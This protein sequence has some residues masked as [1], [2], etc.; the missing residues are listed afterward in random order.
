MKIKVSVTDTLEKVITHKL[1]G[2]F[3]AQ[4]EKK[5]FQKPNKNQNKFRK[6]I[7]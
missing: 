2:F 7:K 3:L 1:H 4:P 5:T 6:K